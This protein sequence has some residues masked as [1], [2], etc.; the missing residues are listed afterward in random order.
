MMKYINLK[1][2]SIVVLMIILIS[3]VFLSVAVGTK[4]SKLQTLERKIALV[5]AQNRRL[6]DDLLANQSL[7][8]ISEKAQE[9]GFAP[10]DSILYIG[11]SAP[12]AKLP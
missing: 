9:L 10:A 2:Y 12:L 5:E 8:K 1:K 6:Q 11:K 7:T 4:G 3:N